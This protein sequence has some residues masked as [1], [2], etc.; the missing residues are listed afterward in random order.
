MAHAD[1]LE[2]REPVEARHAKVEQQ[3]VGMQSRD[4][5][6][7]LRSIPRLTDDNEPFFPT[8][9]LFHA[10]QEQW[11]VVCNQDIHAVSLLSMSQW[12]HRTYDVE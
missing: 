11:M 3:E 7:D 2:T 10:R 8:E 1:P 12:L 5:G 4:Q 9:K 6:Q